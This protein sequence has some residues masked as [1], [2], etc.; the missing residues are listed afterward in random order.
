MMREINKTKT[1]ACYRLIAKLNQAFAKGKILMLIAFLTLVVGRQKSHAQVYVNGNY[2]VAAGDTVS[3]FSSDLTFGPNASI[4]VNGVWLIASSQIELHSTATLT[5]TGTVVLDE[6]SSFTIGSTALSDATVEL[7]GKNM[8]LDCNVELKNTSNL[9]LVNSGLSL[10]KDFDFVS[11]DAHVILG[12]QDLTFA[13]TATVSGYTENRYLVTDGSGAMVK[14]GLSGAFTFPVGATEGTLTTQDY[15]PARLTNT[16]TADA[17]SVRVDQTVSSDNSTGVNDVSREWEITEGTA[18][19]SNVKVELQHNTSTEE[20]S[21]SNSTSY[22]AN[23]IGTAPNIDGGNESINEWDMNRA[24]IDAGTATGVLTSGTALSNASIQDRTFTSFTNTLFTVLSND[25]KCLSAKV[26]LQGALLQSSNSTM[27][28]SLRVRNLIPLTEPYTSL[29]GFS[30]AG[31]GGGETTTT[32]VLS[33]SGN[34]AI[35][36][37]VILDLID[38]SSNTTIT[39]SRS[40]LLQR[41]G[42][43]VS[44]LGDD[45]MCFSGLSNDSFYIGIRHRNHLPIQ[46]SAVH[47]IAGNFPSID[48][49]TVSVYGSNSLV[50]I[51][52]VKAMWAGDANTDSKV[53]ISGV[54]EDESPVFNG[55]TNHPSNPFSSS[56]FVY[57]EYSP[58]D[59]NMDGDVIYTGVK[60]DTAPII[61]N[62]VAHPGNAFK[63]LT[64]QIKNTRP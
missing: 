47:N 7:D 27:T 61:N 13:S 51:N 26:Y 25:D 20:A 39:E 49:N 19:G 23:Y 4:T 52:G 46:T 34:N 30:H 56:T 33:T 10:G 17:Y 44:T 31:S 45:A 64:Y 6:R 22:V 9:D 14:Q 28:D 55:V 2:A 11:D 58:L 57:E 43:V 32:S 54:D 24:S 18:G 40:V 63:I 37:W 36:D 35:V 5:G 8:L 62:V 29:S 15:T 53:I 42:D 16:G 3:I 59:I 50:S 60:N 41:D 48:F 12:N 1:R 21:F 38:K